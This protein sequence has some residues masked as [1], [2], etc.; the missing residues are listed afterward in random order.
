[1][2]SDFNPLAFLDPMWS[3]D[4]VAAHGQ[5]MEASNSGEFDSTLVAARSA[6]MTLQN[7]HDAAVSRRDLVAEKQRLYRALG[8]CQGELG[9]LRLDYERVVEEAGDI[10]RQN[11]LLVE[12][13]LR[14]W[15][16]MATLEVE[17]GILETEKVDMIH[18]NNWSYTRF[19]YRC[20][21]NSVKQLRLRNTHL[22]TYG[23]CPNKFVF[24]DTIRD[25]NSEIDPP[26]EPFP[27]MPDNYGVHGYLSE[28]DD[29]FPWYRDC[30][31]PGG[32]SEPPDAE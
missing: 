5:A 15:D 8:E 27:P 25:Y 4:A 21:K 22:D 23:V 32:P 7:L 31:G 13:I 29:E 14:A 18:M 2:S 20:F 6:M 12:D 30:D 9:A 10:R 17:K 28:R 24:G 16:R 19:D 1:M 11:D 26:E 3:P